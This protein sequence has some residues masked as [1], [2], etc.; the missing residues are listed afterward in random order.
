[1]IDIKFNSVIIELRKS[2]I[3]LILFQFFYLGIVEVIYLINLEYL[4]ISIIMTLRIT[5]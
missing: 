3:N 5:N 4:I 2:R 1:L